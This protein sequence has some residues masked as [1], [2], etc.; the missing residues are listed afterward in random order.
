LALPLL[1][2]MVPAFAAIRNTAAAP[3]PRLGVVYLPNGMA[4]EYWTPAAQGASFELTPVLQPLAPFRDRLLVLSG[5]TSKTIEG[6]GDNHA[7]ASGRFL[8]GVLPKHS[9]SSDLRAAVSMDQIA[10]KA[11]GQHTQLASLELALDSRDFAGACD[12]GF[13]CAYTNTISWNSPTTPLPMEDNPRAVFERLFGDGGSTDP[14]AR[15]VR[16]QQNRSILDSVTQKIAGLARQL[17][18]GDG[19]KLNEYL[20]AVRDVERRIQNAERQPDADLPV[21][22]RPA[23]V[24]ATFKEHARMMFDLQVLAYQ[25]DL[26]RVITFMLGRELTGRVYPEIGIPDSHHPLSHHKND[27]AI[28][29]KLAKINVYHATLFAEYL[30]KL[31]STPD[32]DGSLLDHMMIMYG[33]GM[34]NSNEHAPDHLPL[35]LVGGG[36]GQLT[37]GLH[38]VFPTDT[39]VSNLHLTVLDKLGVA[40]DKLGYSTEKLASF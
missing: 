14:T 34:S 15:L 28:I 37:G 39:P 29:A 22:P 40:V 19:T 31:R 11:L 6:G 21:V 35:L 33:A 5:L 30:E 9:Q 27:P 13:S 24:P 2:G 12:V 32:G 1:D 20:E 16:I 25:C 18:P 3:R 10:A 17:G 23:G 7:N 38:L 8:T 4:M 26:T 36:S